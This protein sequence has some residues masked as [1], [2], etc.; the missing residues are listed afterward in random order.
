MRRHSAADWV[1]MT[2]SAAIVMSIAPV[3]HANRYLT[4]EDAQRLAFPEATQFAEAH[5]VFR[6]GEIAAIERLSGQRVRTRGQQ[7]WKALAGG[8]LAGFFVVDYV[9]G[10]HLA[11]DYS[12][13]LEPDGRVR[14]VE[15]LE[16]REAYGSEITSHSWLRQFMGK[17]GRDPVAVDKD[18]R[19]ISGATLSSQHVTEGIKR[20]LAVY[21]TCLR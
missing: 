15:V 7:I 11:I 19:N 14:S 5:I 17:T 6:P 21:D 9:I 3:A 18:I 20:V 2:A 13:A 4:V 12:V 16:Y 10:K 8:R 1:R